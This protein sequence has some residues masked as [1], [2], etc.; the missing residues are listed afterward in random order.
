MDPI[1]RTPLNSGRIGGVAASGAKAHAETI[2]AMKKQRE[3]IAM[4]AAE[5]IDR[6]G[7]Q[8]RLDVNV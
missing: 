8:S 6:E 5:Q 4:K 2:A 7:Q 3:Q 1:S